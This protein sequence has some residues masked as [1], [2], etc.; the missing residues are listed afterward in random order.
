MGGLVIGI[1][2][3]P[4]VTSA[5][6]PVVT[7][8]PRK[9]QLVISENPDKVP[10]YKL[11]VNDPRNSVE[12]SERK[13]PSL[14]GPPIV[15]TRDEAT[16]IEVKNATSHPTAIHWHGIELESF[17]DGVPGW[18]G[19]GQ[20]TTP[21]ILPGTSFV[22]H[23]TPP[24]AGTFIYHTHWHDDEQLLNGMYGALIVLEPGQ[25]YDP[26][27]D[28]TFV[29]GTG[30]YAPFGEM[31]LVNG[32]PEP[33]PMELKTGTIYRLR[34]INITNNES[35]LRVR[36]DSKEVPVQWTVIAKD[37][38]DLPTAQRKTGPADMGVTVGTTYDVEYRSD[39]VG[40]VEM[41]IAAPLFGALIMQPLDFVL[42][43]VVIGNEKTQSF[44]ERTPDKSQLTR[45]HVGTCKSADQT[46]ETRGN[47]LVP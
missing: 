8:A 3:V 40:H 33:A 9:L 31:L 41:L 5:P 39:R 17:Y 45:S 29:I 11:K 2:V 34:L 42:T 43:Q 36:L 6:I 20:Q 46:S 38:A 16:E 30:R 27:R 25:E 19:S 26:E 47:A 37:G 23:M 1:T 44:P 15:L 7:K 12:P 10:L 32:A 35:D 18:T 4:G 24:R 13:Q 28:K 22:A 21:P 14:L